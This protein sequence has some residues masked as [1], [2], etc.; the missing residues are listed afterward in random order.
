MA[1]AA[2]ESPAP[3]QRPKLL[4]TLL[5]AMVLVGLLPLTVSH[6]FLIGMNRD[7]LETLEK[8]YLTRSAVTIAADVNNLLTNNP[9]QLTKVAASI[10][11]MRA[12]LPAGSDPYVF[13]AQ[14]NVITDY[15]TPDGDLLA[16]R[17]LNRTGQGAEAKPAQMDASI[18][19]EMAL[20]VQAASKGQMYVGTFQY[21]TASG[22]PCVVVAVPVVDGGQV[23]GVVE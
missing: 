7:S 21:L 12:A 22:Q 9:Q 16:L 4:W 14:A 8:K 10:R 23:T 5:G 11:T 6:V 18:A 3:R 15:L 20:A 17:I 2:P 19:Q 13:A 1:E